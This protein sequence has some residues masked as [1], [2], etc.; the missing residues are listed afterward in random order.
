AIGKPSS[1]RIGR[2]PDPAAVKIEALCVMLRSRLP[3][4]RL[5]PCLMAIC[6]GCLSANPVR[7]YGDGRRAFL[8][9]PPS[10]LTKVNLFNR[11]VDSGGFPGFELVCC[12]AYP[13]GSGWRGWD[14]R[15]CW[16]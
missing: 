5:G 9:L 7:I 11:L 1:T 6:P 12:V 3:V 14:G 8:F 16:L 15:N 13:H 2:D 4:P 10:W